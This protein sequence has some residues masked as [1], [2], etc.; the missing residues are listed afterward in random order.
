VMKTDWRCLWKGYWTKYLELRGRKM[1]NKVLHNLYSQLQWSAQRG[2]EGQDMQH[3][4]GSAHNVLVGKAEGKRSVRR[5][6]VQG[7]GLDSCSSRKDL[8]HAFRKTVT[9]LWF[10]QNARN[11]FSNCVT[12]SSPRRTWLQSWDNDGGATQAFLSMAG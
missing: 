6:T 11:F 7:C 3:A 1:H 5:P 9:N 2:W 10:P 4:W 8:C 12:N